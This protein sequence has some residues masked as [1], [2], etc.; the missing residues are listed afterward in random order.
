MS[1]ARLTLTNPVIR[2]FAPDPSI[3]RVGEWYYVATSSF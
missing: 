3:I 1:G 2:G